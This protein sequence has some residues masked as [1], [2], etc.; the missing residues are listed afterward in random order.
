MD[1][2]CHSSFHFIPKKMFNTPEQSYNWITRHKK[3]T[4]TVEAALNWFKDNKDSFLK[5]IKNG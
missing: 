2:F 4:R 3:H 5:A 1:P